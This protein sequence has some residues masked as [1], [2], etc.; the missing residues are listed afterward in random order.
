MKN[1]KLTI[2]LDT[3]IY[4]RPFDSKKDYK[5]NVEANASVLIFE[6]IEKGE[7]I[8][9]SSDILEYEISKAPIN[10]R[11]QMIS[12]L[13]LTHRSVSLTG[14]I[15][16]IAEKIHKECKIEPRDAL[17]IASA[18]KG[19]AEYFL[20]CDNSVIKKAILLKKMGLSIKI[21]NPLKFLEEVKI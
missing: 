18:I 1:K 7:I 15:V 5:V 21:L 14:E 12:L 3:N 9:I 16:K 17:H 10:K 13:S 8:C 4:G 20:T 6:L 19:K 11:T 2:Y